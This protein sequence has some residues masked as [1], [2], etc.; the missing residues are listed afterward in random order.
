MGLESFVRNPDGRKIKKIKLA[1]QMLSGYIFEL[2]TCVRV[3]KCNKICVFKLWPPGEGPASHFF[4]AGR[5]LPVYDVRN[6]SSTRM[7]LVV[8]ELLQAGHC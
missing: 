5:A 1:T 4:F 8:K 6:C 3:K 7:T 2:Y